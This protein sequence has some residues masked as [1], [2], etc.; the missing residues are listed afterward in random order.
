MFLRVFRGEWLKRRRSFASAMILGG[1]LFTPA[2][3][4]VVRLLHPHALRAVYG[5]AEF[6]PRL[7]RDSWE[8]MAIFF[9]PLGAIL[10]TSLV[11]QI[12]LR[13]NAWKQLHTLPVS[14]P[15]LFA[16]KL[17]VI[18]LML[19][20]FL[21]LFNA[22][23]YLSA[24][25]PFLLMPGVPRPAGSF[26]GLP[27]LRE[28]ALYFLDCLPIA[29]AQYLLALRSQNVLVP[30]G[31]GFV[32]WVGALAAVS[33]K[34]AL[35]WPY[36]YTIVHY[37]RDKPKGAHLAAAA[38]SYHWLAAASFVLLTAASYWLFRTNRA[39]G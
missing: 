26:L 15:V 18:L 17:L 1:S 20:E 21:L 27:L 32:A 10:A 22:G 36:A 11:T 34:A 37:L 23:I 6:W 16:A 25:L 5:A 35:W 24:M 39:K 3:I 33:S 12:E 13:G 4:V 31:I 29:G 2:I 9:L 19:A 8:S 7:W 28:N 38:V 30:I 14:V